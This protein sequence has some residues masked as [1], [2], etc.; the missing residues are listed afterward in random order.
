VFEAG[1]AYFMSPGH[2]P[3]AE[4]GSEF[5]QFSPSDELHASEAVMMENMQKMQA[6]ST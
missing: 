2:V 1:D 5:V 4:S 3:E 6:P